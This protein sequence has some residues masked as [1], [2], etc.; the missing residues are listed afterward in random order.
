LCRK[1][2]KKMPESGL[3]TIFFAL[4][5]QLWFIRG[6]GKAEESPNHC[7]YRVGSA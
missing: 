2:A 3:P 4:S 1:L 7:G 6:D 5:R